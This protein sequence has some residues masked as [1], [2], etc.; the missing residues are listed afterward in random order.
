[1]VRDIGLDAHAS[2]FPL[3]VRV[4]PGSTPLVRT[5]QKRPILGRKEC[6]VKTKEVQ[7]GVQA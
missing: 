7:R 6:H 5:L 4:L 3:G 1:M 2:S